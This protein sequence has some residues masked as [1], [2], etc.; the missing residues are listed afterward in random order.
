[1]HTY[2]MHLLVLIDKRINLV[3]LFL[4]YA[5]FLQTGILLSNYSKLVGNWRYE[6]ITHI[7]TK[8]RC[9]LCNEM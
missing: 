2:S 9:Q 6:S 7:L 3:P 1:M 5:H 8:S 4:I